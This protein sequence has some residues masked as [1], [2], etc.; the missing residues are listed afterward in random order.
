MTNAAHINM[1]RR[2][3]IRAW[4]P[5]AVCPSALLFVAHPPENLDQAP[6]V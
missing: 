6:F 2:G 5:P 3:R 1:T 4:R